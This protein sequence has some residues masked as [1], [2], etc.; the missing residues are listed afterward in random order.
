M[1]RPLDLDLTKL[2]SRLGADV[3]AVTALAFSPDGRFLAAANADNKIAVWDLQAP[4]KPLA[5]YEGSPLALTEPIMWLSLLQPTPGKTVLMLPGND[6]TTR[7][8]SVGAG[9]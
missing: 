1:A 9:G 4:A 3:A 6:G 7:R 2:S 5:E 8:I